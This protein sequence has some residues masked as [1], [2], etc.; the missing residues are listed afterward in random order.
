M[1]SDYCLSIIHFASHD[2]HIFDFGEDTNSTT[3]QGMPLLKKYK[4]QQ[5]IVCFYG[6]IQ[7]IFLAVLLDGANKLLH[8]FTETDIHFSLGSKVVRLNLCILLTYMP[9]FNVCTYKG[10]A[11]I[12]TNS[13][14]VL[15]I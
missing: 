15:P 9:L 1:C 10:N 12:W 2:C 7:T 11:G 5:L 3:K 8:Y 4:L 14:V 6:K 13:R